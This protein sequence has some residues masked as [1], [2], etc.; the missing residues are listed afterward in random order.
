MGLHLRKPL[1]NAHQKRIFPQT[2]PRRDLPGDLHK[3]V[4]VPPKAVTVEVHVCRRVQSLE[5]QAHHRC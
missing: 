4:V 5:G 2:Q 1:I 3:G